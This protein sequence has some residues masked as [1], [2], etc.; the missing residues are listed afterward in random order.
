MGIAHEAN[1]YARKLFI[2]KYKNM[3]KNYNTRNIGI[4]AHVDAGKTTLTER[5]LYYTGQI[6]RI[7]NVDDGNTTMDTDAIERQKGITISSAA[8][9]TKWT[10]NE[11]TYQINIIDTPGHIDFMVEV[12]RSL[13]V[14]DGVVALL[15]A[16]SGVQ[17]QTEQ[18]W[19]QAVKYD[20]PRLCFINKMDRQGA[21][22]FAIVEEIR[23]QLSTIPL[24]LQI[25]IGAEDSFCGVIDLIEEKAMYWE[26]ETG[27]IWLTRPIP[28]AMLPMA[29]EYRNAL[30]E[31]LAEHDALFFERYF[32]EEP[33][34]E[35][36]D[37]FDAIR[38]TTLKGSLTPIL[39]GAAYRNKAV[40]P[41]I[42]AIAKFLPAPDDRPDVE[43]I[44]P[45]TEEVVR[46]RR[47]TDEHFSAL[48]FKIV[49]DKF[50]G[51]LTMVRVYS[52][53][54]ACGDTLYLPRT[55]ERVRISRILQIRSNKALDIK[56]AVAGDIVGL[57]GIKDIRTG[58]TICSQERQVILEAISFPVPVLSLAIE[59]KSSEDERL[60][61]KVLSN[62]LLEDPSLSIRMDEQ[63]G[64]T[65]LS[66]MGEL[67]LEV[68]I[69][70]MLLNHG[71][72]VITGKPKVFYKE[73]FTKT[74][75]WKERFVKQNSG[76]GQF[77]EIVFAI[78]PA[79]DGFEGLD[80][81]DDVHGGVIPK[82]FISYVKKGFEAAMNEG[83]IGGF[84]LENMRI[85][86]K[87]GS[88]HKVDSHA[89]DFE[90]AAR[91]AFREMAHLCMPVLM[92]PIMLVEIVGLEEHTGSISGDINRR[93][94]LI[95]SISYKNGRNI[96]LA[97]VPLSNT[98]GYISDLR[99]ITSGRASISLRLSHFQEVSN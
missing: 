98:F 23:T 33:L 82:E 89:M 61:A 88:T 55:R 17:P 75:E 68:T 25:P 49:T 84:P 90:I 30:L 60:F 52:G 39:C 21:D 47:E 95:Q 4:I 54:I 14:L 58:D 11:E 63:T 86:L 74:V 12:E 79:E 10:V 57:I 26:D 2:L 71:L 96:F 50:M 59:P 70:R 77:A 91:N 81:V 31:T 48:A 18:V 76:S 1:L 46:L 34:L 93:K 44:V 69:E 38:R 8:I 36:A 53:Q 16:T 20:I 78:G 35:N 92:E 29:I 41:L 67:H 97:W 62:V 32:G 27:D 37:I 80:F 22:F 73:K 85:V 28:E 56:N 15:C 7:G 19:F 3:R 87:D 51:K 66:G 72:E 42:D 13:R 24:E 64:Q 9:S 65:I 94:G 99:T 45:E 6:H 40:Q 43:G 5:I 83:P